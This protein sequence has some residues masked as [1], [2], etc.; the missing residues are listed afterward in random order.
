MADY[1][2]P[3]GFIVKGIP[4]DTNKYTIYTRALDERWMTPEDIGQ[5]S[6][7]P[8][9]GMTGM[10]KFKSGIGQGMTHVARSLGNLAGLISE[11]DMD[12]ALAL[13][14]SLLQ[15]GAGL[16]GSITG[17][18]AATLPIGGG[19]GAAAKGLTAARSASMVGR[20]AN[21]LGKAL[22]S[23]VGRGTVEG[24]LTGAI[25]A[26]HDDRAYMGGFGAGL[27]GSFGG[28]GKAMGYAWRNFKLPWVNL[29]KEAS[30]HMETTGGGFI[31]LS[32]SLP[33]G[34]IMKMFYESVLG[35][36]PGATGKIR[37]QFR[38]ALD[39]FRRVASEMTHPPTAQV[40]DDAL[41]RMVPLEFA[42]GTPMTTIF[43]QLDDYWDNAFDAAKRADVDVGA[44]R[45][46]AT[47]QSTVDDLSGG[48][49]PQLSG[50][51]KGG[52]LLDLRNGLNRVMADL[53]P[54][55]PLN[56]SI[57]GQ[58]KAVIKQIDEMM[59]RSLP[60]DIWDDLAAKRPY[61]KSYLD[62]T[63]AAQKAGKEGFEASPAQL[64]GT[65]AQRGGKAARIGEG[66]ELQQVSQTAY[67]VLP[68]FPSR[69]GIYQLVAALGLGSSMI[70][71]IAGTGVPAL[72]VGGM[73]ALGKVM[74]SKAFQKAITGQHGWAAKA[75]ALAKGLRAAGYSGRQIA[76]ILAA[77]TR[78]QNNATGR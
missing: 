28:L 43:K 75:D 45:L 71:F 77:E 2:L 25:L 64:A 70:G 73:Y 47:V 48:M 23:P 74:S 58:Y 31:P 15:T 12:E 46:P 1:R 39:D 26:E 63:K 53:D 50:K 51:V 10:E 8:T 54:T 18:V 6:Y 33:E 9:E 65:T 60:R 14:S 41:Q 21:M 52:Q 37:G 59:E 66:T 35:N 49:F 3:N 38:N 61:Y 19:V 30:K 44:W 4:D 13:D 72:A 40:Y 76:V 78:R 42:P 36:M 69:P 34:G 24:G 16:A 62:L 11:E 67:K 57:R 68:D 56:Q 7:D 5:D 29:S 27:G 22:A 32:H 55:Q 20:G 17:Q